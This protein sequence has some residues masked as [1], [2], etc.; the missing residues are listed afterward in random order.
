MK[1]QLALEQQNK[2]STLFT[3]YLICSLYF[4]FRNDETVFDVF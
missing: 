1:Y 2:E 3:S 4:T